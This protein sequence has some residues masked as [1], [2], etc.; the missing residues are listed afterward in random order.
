MAIG[1]PIAGLRKAVVLGQSTSAQLLERQQGR[2]RQE[3]AQKATKKAALQKQM[4]LDPKSWE[5]DWAY[6]DK[7][8]KDY[9]NKWA[10]KLADSEGNLSVEDQR[11]WANDKRKIEREAQVSLD[12][13]KMYG[14]SFGTLQKTPGNYNVPK[15]ELRLLGLKEPRQHAMGAGQLEE[16]NRLGPVMYRHQY[17]GN[18]TFLK[19]LYNPIQYLNKNYGA[20]L[21]EII[22]KRKTAFENE[23]GASSKTVEERSFE[24]THNLV[25][26]V[27][28]ND[29]GWQASVNN[30]YNDSPELKA[31]FP[32]VNDYLADIARTMSLPE[33]VLETSF[34]IK[35]PKDKA[36]QLGTTQENKRNLGL[37]SH[38]VKF[39][40]GVAEF[41]SW[42]PIQYK[43]KEDDEKVNIIIPVSPD[44]AVYDASGRRGEFP[45]DEIRGRVIGVGTVPVLQNTDNFLIDQNQAEKYK[46]ATD[47][48]VMYIIR[49]E[50]GNHIPVPKSWI[51][52]TQAKYIEDAMVAPL[53]A[54]QQEADELNQEEEWDKT[55]F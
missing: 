5:A 19:P 42:K 53:R 38:L 24:D 2:L 21:K 4:M 25:R 28:L 1:D 48:K 26:D 23:A 36:I 15:S 11:E 12:Y 40:K 43:G 6:F 8:G 14:D 22:Q 55:D 34:E 10:Q 45:K 37:D 16:Y 30:T 32:T 47:Y 20:K 7:L 46:D 3:T 9:E 44:Q 17:M 18:E 41:S 49:D 33:R 51:P 31:Q 13:K 35:A 50:N 29:Q 27:F 52:P 54:M 39:G